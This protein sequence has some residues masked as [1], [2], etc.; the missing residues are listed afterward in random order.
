AISH[1]STTHTTPL[2][3]TVSLKLHPQP[4][5]LSP[6]GHDQPWLIGDHKVLLIIPG[7][8]ARPVEAAVQQDPRVENRKL[9]VHVK[10]AAIDPHRDAGGD[11]SL[12][13]RA[14]I[15]GLV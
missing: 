3:K 13:V 9:V 12:D 5:E 1:P 11:E 7:R 2:T 8:A 15:V 6:E 4:L 14:Q 10:W